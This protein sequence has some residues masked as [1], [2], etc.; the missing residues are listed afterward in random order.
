MKLLI[1]YASKTG[2]TAKIAHRI[3]DVARESAEV[4]VVEVRAVPADVLA[5]CDAIIVATPVRFDHHPRR[6]IEFV[7]NNLGRLQ[8]IHSALVSVSGASMTPAGAHQAE[9]YVT[10]F[11]AQTRWTPDQCELVAGAM[12]FTKYDPFTRFIIRRIARAKGLST[13]TSRDHDYTDWDEIDR[14]AKAFVARAAAA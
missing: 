6:V 7:R 2:Q 13:D 11:Q 14:V 5:A 3:A 1:V 9:D 8:S 12:P 10:S 4:T